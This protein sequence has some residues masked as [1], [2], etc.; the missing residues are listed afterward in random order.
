MKKGVV[1][2]SGKACPCGRILLCSSWAHWSDIQLVW[3]AIQHATFQI[4]VSGYQRIWLCRVFQD[5]AKREFNWGP[6]KRFF[7]GHVLPSQAHLSTCRDALWEGRTPC[8]IQWAA[9]QHMWS[10]HLGLACCPGRHRMGE[11]AVATS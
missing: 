5:Q 7:V 4:R 9:V 11:H 2:F 3:A 6:F 8:W 10:S 1:P